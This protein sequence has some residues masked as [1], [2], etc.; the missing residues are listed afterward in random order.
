MLF[1]FSIKNILHH[2]GF[3]PGDSAES[4]LRTLGQPADSFCHFLV[5]D[6]AFSIA[7]NFQESCPVGFKNCVRIEVGV[8]VDAEV[9]GRNARFSLTGCT[10]HS[11]HSFYVT[12]LREKW[13]S[14]TANC[15][16]NSDL[17]CRKQ[18]LFQLRPHPLPSYQYLCSY[19]CRGLLNTVK[20]VTNLYFHVQ[21]LVSFTLW[22]VKHLFNFTTNYVIKQ[23]SSL[24][25]FTVYR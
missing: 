23:Q 3:N 15:I 13:Y 7:T 12:Q 14:K 19:I 24:H 2:W 6:A 1:S 10:F 18:E 20:S 8:H 16:W 17:W 25:Q 9:S 11:F 22:V 4:C 5:P 21:C